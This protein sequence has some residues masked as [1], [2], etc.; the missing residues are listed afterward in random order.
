MNPHSLAAIV[1]AAGESKRM[2]QPKMSLPWGKTTVIGQV[3]T[4]LAQTGIEDIIVV[5]GGG[6][7]ELLEALAHLP[8]SVHYRTVFNPDYASDEMSRSLQV[9]LGALTDEIQA[10]MVVLGDQP[11]IESEVV[12][13]VLSAYDASQAALVIPS[14]QMRRGHPWIVERSLWPEIIAL[15]NPATLRHFLQA[16]SDKIHYVNVSRPSILIDLDTPQQYQES[17]PVPNDS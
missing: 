9:G 13:E 7:A 12:E 2:G 15:R 1:L 10:A 16:Q 17:K 3:V 11:Q 14:Y 5:V 8:S 4:T 6:R